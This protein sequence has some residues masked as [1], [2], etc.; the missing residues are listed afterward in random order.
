MGEMQYQAGC[1][2]SVTAS[3]L[4]AH[5]QIETPLAAASK[6]STG[7]A[8]HSNFEK[9]SSTINAREE[10]WSCPTCTFFNKVS[11]YLACEICGEPKRSASIDV[12]ADREQVTSLE[13]QEY[14]LRVRER[15]EKVEEEHQNLI[16][17]RL[18]EIIEMQHQLFGNPDAEPNTVPSD[19]EREREL[20]RIEREREQQRLEREGELQRV[21]REREQLK[22]E[23]EKIL[24]QQ[25]SLDIKLQELKQT[26]TNSTADARGNAEERELRNSIPTSGPGATT[27]PPP[28]AVSV[29]TATPSL[30]DRKYSKLEDE[31]QQLE[32]QQ[33]MTRQSQPGAT[34][35]AG[36]GSNGAS[37]HHQACSSEKKLERL[38]SERQQLLRQQQV[39]RS[40]TTTR[41]GARA[42]PGPGASS[43]Q[44]GHD[45]DQLR[46]QRDLTREQ[47]EYVKTWTGA[48]PSLSSPSRT[49][50]SHSAQAFP[51]PQ[52][53]SNAPTSVSS[54]TADQQQAQVQMLLQSQRNSDALQSQS[55]I[56]EPARVLST[57]L[58]PT[59]TPMSHSRPR[60]CHQGQTGNLQERHLATVGGMSGSQRT[61]I[62]SGLH[63]RPRPPEVQNV[64]H[65]ARHSLNPP[66]PYL[67]VVCLLHRRHRTRRHLLRADSA[68]AA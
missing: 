33:R 39:C 55:S 63:S 42:V 7:S 53:R 1:G 18:E 62:G 17:A 64:E 21:E 65:R 43:S 13:D 36:V 10:G 44:E 2:G 52:T 20:Q 26:M 24:K 60:L 28:G 61:E 40:T 50:S 45:L 66:H 46:D 8:Y 47:Q 67:L 31:R 27:V 58:P 6:S 4:H 32:H 22:L 11:D 54:L 30:L 19:S 16:N 37:D 23:E 49:A 57:R 14:Q 15:E 51:A 34:A 5:Q 29:S 41:P 48:V 12:C 59:R 3:Y 68:R 9:V 38:E 56:Q 25:A 35:V